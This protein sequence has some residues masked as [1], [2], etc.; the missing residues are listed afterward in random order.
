M[1]VQVHLVEIHHLPPRLRLALLWMYSTPQPE[2]PINKE[3][4]M[5]QGK[6]PDKSRAVF[7]LSHS[8]MNEQEVPE[9]ARSPG[10]P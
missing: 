7:A 4:Q 9:E 2:R 8:I 1:S 5:Y 6:A 10:K 3:I